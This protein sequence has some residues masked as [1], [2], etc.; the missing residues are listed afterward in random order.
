[1]KLKFYLF[2]VYLATTKIKK[3]EIKNIDEVQK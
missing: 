1:M 2:N 3:K